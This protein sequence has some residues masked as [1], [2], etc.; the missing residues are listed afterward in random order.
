MKRHAQ[1]VWDMPMKRIGLAL[2]SLLL[3][4]LL[5]G[6]QEYGKVVQGRTVAYDKDKKIVTIIRETA[7]DRLNPRYNALPPM[8]FQLPTDPKE[9]GPEPKAAQRIEF[10]P[11]QNQITIYDAA[12]Q[13]FKTIDFVEKA[14]I[15]SNINRDDPLVNDAATGKPKNYPII[16]K[17]KKTIT[18]YSRRLKQLATFKVPDQYFGMP[19]S[20]WDAGEEVRIFYREDGKAARFQNMSKTDIY[21]K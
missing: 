12:T 4:A 1:G 3:P 7:H 9:T 2:L 8:T 16:D 5:A 15:K 19:E 20:T 6:C 11:E 17:E 13:T 10:K 21:K 18:I 14:D